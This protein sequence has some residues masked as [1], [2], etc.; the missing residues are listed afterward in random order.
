MDPNRTIL[1]FGYDH[2]AVR[3]SDSRATNRLPDLH[4]PRANPNLD[5]SQRCIRSRKP[6]PPTKAATRSPMT[7]MQVTA[8][9]KKRKK[10][11]I[12]I[13]SIDWMHL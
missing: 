7:M 4:P 9:R 11:S 12:I 6:P 5:R 8:T 3:L 1:S 2:Q 10:N 13:N